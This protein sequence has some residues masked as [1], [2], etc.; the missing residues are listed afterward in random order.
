MLF[1]KIEAAIHREYRA[2]LKNSIEF[3]RSG[4]EYDKDAGIRKY[5]TDTR[6][7]QYTAGAITRKAAIGYATARATKEY[8]KDTDKNIEF[9]HRIENGGTLEEISI[10]VEW[11]KSCVWGY[12]PTATATIKWIDNNGNYQ[13]IRYTGHASGC[14]YDKGSAAV[15]DALNQ[16]VAVRAML[17]KYANR[18][19]TREVKTGGAAICYGCGYAAIPYF[20]GGVGVGCF[21][22]AFELCGYAWN[23]NTAAKNTDYYYITKK[24]RK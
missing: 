2:Y 20:E 6:W 23:E 12:N 7:N 22:K 11:Y 9:L 17:C 16:S 19:Y 5:S 8:Q 10:V 13:Y 21:R 24:G 4:H 14:G 3:I 1:K 15:A 18:R